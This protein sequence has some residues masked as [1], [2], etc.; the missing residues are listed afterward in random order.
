MAAFDYAVGK[1]TLENVRVQSRVAELVPSAERRAAVN[2]WLDGDKSV[3]L[4]VAE[5]EAA[6]MLKTEYARFLKEAQAA[7]VLEEGWADYAPRILSFAKDG[8]SKFLEWLKARGQGSGA[9]F[10]RARTFPTIA[11][12][13]ASP[14]YR[15][16]S[17]R[18]KTED[19]ADLYGKYADSMTKVIKRKELLN[20]LQKLPVPGGKP[21]QTI[22]APERMAPKGYSP[23]PQVPGLMVHPDVQF[24]LQFAY[25]AKTPLGFWRAYDALNSAQ[26]LSAVMGSLFHATSLGYAYAGSAKVPL[27][28]MAAGA[29]IGAGAAAVWDPDKVSNWAQLG[30]GIGMFAPFGALAFKAVSGTHPIFKEI[31]AAG[32]GPLVNSALRDGVR[33]SIER[34][35]ALEDTR[36][37]AFTA[38]MEDA[39]TLAD[40]TLPGLGKAPRA[41]S[42]VV[43]A[44]DKYM[45][46]R[47][48]TTLKLVTYQA[49]KETI[50]RNNALAAERDPAKVKILSDEE[51]GKIAA[52]YTN[53]MFGGLNWRQIASEG[54]SR[55]TRELG[56]RSLNPTARKWQQRLMFAPDWFLSTTRA[57]TQAFQDGAGVKGLMNPRTLADLHRQYIARSA[58]FYMLAGDGL[59]YAMSGHHIWQNKKDANGTPQWWRLELGDGR[60]M[61]FNK[62]ALE[63]V[64]LLNDPAQTL[65]NKLAKPVAEGIEQITGKEYISAHGKA[66]PMDTSTGGRALHALR[67]FEPIAAQSSSATGSVAAGV[68][69]SLGIPIYGKSK[70]DIAFEK[71]KKAMQSERAKIDKLR[72]KL[73]GAGQ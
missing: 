73:A 27:K 38:M 4:S 6:S 39:G 58:L 54:K 24:A 1:R 12:L 21:K 57:F 30:A 47:L 25:D 69:G 44:F 8:E 53:D 52:S 62:H 48:H 17:M 33:F 20:D 49:K 51:A 46:S 19:A 10:T 66:P 23:I 11:E 16:G 43:R 28:T 67:G 22:V 71:R 68:A 59:N 13:K 7:G 35:G 5:Q 40:K 14:L 61:S 45:W 26:K 36:S 37:D 56:E 32:G 42:A 29:A 3:K 34:H 72:K 65:A 50:L 18:L 2:L 15:D 63:I 55:W 31:K 64:H 41:I 70:A 9:S 60:T